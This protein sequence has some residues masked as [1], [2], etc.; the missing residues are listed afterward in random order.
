MSPLENKTLKYGTKFFWPIGFGRHGMEISVN[1]VVFMDWSI[2]DI[3]VL[4]CIRAEND[5]ALQPFEPHILTIQDHV[6]EI[7]VNFIV[8]SDYQLLHLQSYCI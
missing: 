5:K 7:S 4:R 2:S 8:T 1:F 3:S 6:M